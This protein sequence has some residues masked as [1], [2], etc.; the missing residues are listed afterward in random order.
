MCKNNGNLYLLFIYK[1]NVHFLNLMKLKNYTII[2]CPRHQSIFT[3]RKQWKCD[4]PRGISPLFSDIVPATQNLDSA[5]ISIDR[6]SFST[7]NEL[8][9][10]SVN[11]LINWSPLQR[12]TRVE[13]KDRALDSKCVWDLYYMLFKVCISSSERSVYCKYE[14]LWLVWHCW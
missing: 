11:R 5:I 3:L 9:G 8:K 12:M 1:Q 10:S 7:M 14:I 6:K 2:N 4:T 13:T